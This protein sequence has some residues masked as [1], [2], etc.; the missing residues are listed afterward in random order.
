[1]DFTLEVDKRGRVLLPKA[2]REVLHLRPGDRLRAHLDGQ[3]LTLVPELRA[4]TV[5]I[6]HGWP[7]IDLP[8]GVQLKSHPVAE[9][10]AARDREILG[11]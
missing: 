9:A 3:Q 8:S 4:A 6:E 5:R 11:E 10:R 7:V 2:L 1:M